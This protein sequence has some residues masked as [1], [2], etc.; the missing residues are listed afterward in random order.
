M[1]DQIEANLAEIQPQNHQNVQKIHFWQKVPGV[2]GLNFWDQGPCRSKE[3]C[4]LYRRVN[5]LICQPYIFELIRCR[6]LTFSC[7]LSEIEILAVML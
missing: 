6:R 4:T 1:F 7:F 5:L 3:T 2:N